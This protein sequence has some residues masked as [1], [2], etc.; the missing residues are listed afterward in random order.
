MNLAIEKFTEAIIR[1][2]SEHK[3]LLPFGQIL[4]FK[5]NAL[6]GGIFSYL[7]HTHSHFINFYNNYYGKLMSRLTQSLIEKSKL[8]YIEGVIFR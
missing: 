3:E 1:L 5:S 8:E 2:Q 4:N 6:G 7:N